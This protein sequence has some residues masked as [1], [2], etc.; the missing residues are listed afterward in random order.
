MK[1][2]SRGIYE[3]QQTTYDSDENLLFEVSTEIRNLIADLEKS[4]TEINENEA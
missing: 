2:L 1:Q 4:E 3:S